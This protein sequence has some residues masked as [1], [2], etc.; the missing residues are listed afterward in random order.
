MSKRSIRFKNYQKLK[1]DRRKI[2]LAL[3]LLFQSDKSGKRG[4][5]FNKVLD[6]SLFFSFYIDFSEE[7]Y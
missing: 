5:H 4:N 7:V 1:P 2:T 6:F 3:V